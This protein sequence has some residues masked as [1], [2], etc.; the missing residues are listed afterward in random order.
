MRKMKKRLDFE[1]NFKERD[2]L[3]EISLFF[4]VFEKMILLLFIF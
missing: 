3:D 4:N 2:Y 1:F